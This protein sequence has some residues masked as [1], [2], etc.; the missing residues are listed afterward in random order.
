MKTRLL[1]IT[2]SAIFLFSLTHDVCAAETKQQIDKKVRE[3]A[4][5]FDE[6][7]QMPDHAI[8]D[9]LLSNCSGI[10]IFPNL[11]K[12]GFVFGAQFGTG[13]VVYR[14][15]KT[16]QWSNPS[17]YTIG[18]GS[19]G[20]QIG[21]QVVDLILVIMNE[22]GMQSIAGGSLTLGGDAAASAGPVGRNAEI[23]T[24]ALMKTGIFS[25][26][27]SKGLFAGVTLKGTVLA[28]DSKENEIY[29][30]EALTSE[31]ILLRGKGQPTEQAR[32]LSGVLKRY[33]K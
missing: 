30:G 15:K 33:S 20:L 1:L 31:D 22:R 28:P 11:V 23:G 10:A 9:D 4:A 7:M 25:Y 13:V 24:D 32:E 2:L 21:G 5:L 12:G 18:G 16:K 17:F 14:D 6:V 29:Y 26:S 19:F 8:P 27:R 3:C